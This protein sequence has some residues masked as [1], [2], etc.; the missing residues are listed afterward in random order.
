MSTKDNPG[1]LPINLYA[2]EPPKMQPI[3]LTELAHPKSTEK[4]SN[5]EEEIQEFV[6]FAGQIVCI[7]SD[8][9]CPF[10]IASL[11]ENVTVIMKKAKALVF[12]PDPFNPFHYIEDIQESFNTPG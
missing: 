4:R 5:S 6:F 7:K 2:A 1:T 9:E 12:S 3:D 10:V 8:K 11:L